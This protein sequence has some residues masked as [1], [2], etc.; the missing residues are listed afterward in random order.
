MWS[1]SRLIALTLVAALTLT[2]QEL[3]RA[4]G[5]G[6]AAGTMVL[7]IGG[8]MMVVPMGPDGQPIG[9]AHVCPDAVLAVAAPPAPAMIF[10]T[11]QTVSVFTPTPAVAAPIVRALRLV[12]QARA[13][14]ALA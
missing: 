13:P 12:P 3:A 7:C 1:L 9:P 8:S 6:V 10:P 14:P 5:D 11:V 4:R 2:S